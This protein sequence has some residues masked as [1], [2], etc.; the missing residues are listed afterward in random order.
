MGQGDQDRIQALL[1]GIQ[2]GETTGTVTGGQFSYAPDEMKQVVKNWIE[3]ANS[4]DQSLRN[5]DI[6]VQVLPPAEDFASTAFAKAANSSGRSY[7]AYLQHNRDY[8][9]EQAQLFQDALDDYLGAEERTIIGL[10]GAVESDGPQPG[11]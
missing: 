10:N 11:L 7:M 1:G 5:C 6:I 9:L 8:C 3:L 2:T 4:Y